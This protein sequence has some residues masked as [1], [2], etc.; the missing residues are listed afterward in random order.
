MML[1]MLHDQ[2]VVNVLLPLHSPSFL[3]LCSEVFAFN[4]TS[5]P[6]N[7]GFYFDKVCCLQDASDILLRLSNRCDCIVAKLLLKGR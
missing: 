1:E 6:Q 3:F 2:L 5:D 7:T 4:F